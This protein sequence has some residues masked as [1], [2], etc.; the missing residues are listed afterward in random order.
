MT[1]SGKSTVARSLAA[2]LSIPVIGSGDVAREMAKSDASTAMALDNGMLAPEAAMRLRIEHL[3]EQATIT[4][5]GYVLEGFP[6]SIAQL[7]TLL[8][9]TSN[10]TPMPEFYLLDVPVVECVRR[11]LVR[12]RSDDNPD[13]IAKKIESYEK[14]TLPMIEMLG[15]NIVR[16]EHGERFVDRILERV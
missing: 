12:G 15:P 13:S 9:W 1:G 10:T 7:I 6:R 16:L 2:Q 3:T 4:D 5:G 11:L 8:G 14:T